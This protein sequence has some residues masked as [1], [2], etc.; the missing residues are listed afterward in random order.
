MEPIES[1][2]WPSDTDVELSF[3]RT[4]DRSQ[5][6]RTAVSEVFLTDVRALDER[7][8]VLA[9]QLPSCHSYFNDHAD[10][11]SAVDPLLIMEVGRQA[12]LAS[13]HELGVPADVVLISSGFELRVTDPDLWQEAG[14]CAV[15]RLDSEFTWTRIRRGRPRA[16]T[17]EQRIMLDGRLAARH[18]SSGQLLAPGE[19]AALREAQRGTPPPRSADL[20]DQPDPQ[21][22]PPE[23]AGRRDALNVVLADLRQDGES[24][25]ARVAPRLSNRALF[26]HSYDH[27]TMQVLTEAAR[28]LALIRLGGGSARMAQDWQLIGLT[29]AF[30]RFAELDAVATVRAATPASSGDH[31]TVPVTVSQD[32]ESVARLEVTLVSR[33]EKS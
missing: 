29:G 31:V 30:A 3:D 2:K 11:G 20:A 32:G 23:L 19:L 10:Q 33:T 14:L 16:G 6:H 8:V 27:L 28:Q 22:V 24:F 26:D 7:R 18:C 12:T 25:T 5:V 17:C 21:A 13:A 15:L 1:L 9:G 4:I